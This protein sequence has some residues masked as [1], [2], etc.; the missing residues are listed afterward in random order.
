M[1]RSRSGRHI[2]RLTPGLKG[3]SFAGCGKSCF[4]GWF[5][6]GHDFSHAVKSCKLVTGFSPCVPPTVRRDFSASS[7]AAPHKPFILVIPTSPNSSLGLQPL[8][9]RLH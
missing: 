8:S 7:L 1:E 2:N 6:S 9:Q 4:Y 5:V 3:R